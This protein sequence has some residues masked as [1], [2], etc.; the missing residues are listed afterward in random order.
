MSHPTHEDPMTSTDVVR[1]YVEFQ[2]RL[3]R[4]VSGCVRPPA[5]VLEDAC[6]AA[7]MALIGNRER[8]E[9]ARAPGWLVQTAVHEALRLIALADRENSLDLEL[10]ERAVFPDLGTVPGPEDRVMGW[11]RVHSL[12]R[13]PVRQQRLIW[14]RALGLSYEEMASHEHCTGRT[15]RRQLERAGR[16]L[17]R[18]D[19][20]D[21]VYS[22]AA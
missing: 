17:R 1:L 13:L 19:A 6:Q 14:L 3:Q 4:M 15:V 8:V 11:Q 16:A 22:T 18:L 9:L 10:E 12:A 5:P 7:W 20:E 21:G 2:P